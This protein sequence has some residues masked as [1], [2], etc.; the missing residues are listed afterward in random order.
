[1]GLWA[2]TLHAADPATSFPTPPFEIPERNGNITDYYPGNPAPAHQTVVLIQDLHANVG[3]QKNIA[4]IIYRLHG[5][6]K[7]PRILV[8]VEG[9][10]GEGDVSLLRSL[11]GPIRHGF[12]AFLLHKAYLTGAELAATESAADWAQQG[13]VVWNKMKSWFVRSANPTPVSLS[14]VLLWGV[15]DPALYRKNWHAAKVVDRQKFMALDYMHSTR[16]MIAP[17]AAPELKKHLD[18]VVKLL[19]LRLQPK[20][21]K[22]YLQ[23]RGM[24]PKGPPI[25]MSTLEA[26]ETYYSAA[27]ERSHAMAHNL[28]TRMDHIPGYTVLV[29]GGFH[30]KEIAQELKKKGISYVIITPRVQV[31]DQ[32]EAYRARLRE[33]E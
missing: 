8:C 29:T 3:V 27:E 19:M 31:L 21:Y 15:D 30:T 14:P 9:A 5:I 11:P 28:L 32:D 4:S 12:E 18:L 7:L 17:N 26:A 24:N 22:D 16:T 10:S 23:T 33:E 20:E 25:Y 13:I 2:P 1:M 6:N